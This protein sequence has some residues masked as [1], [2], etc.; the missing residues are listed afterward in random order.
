MPFIH[1]QL[2]LAV[3]MALGAVSIPYAQARGDMGPDASPNGHP[4]LSERVF[5]NVADDKVEQPVSYP[6]PAHFYLKSQATTRNGERL[7]QTIDAAVG[8]LREAGKLTPT[9]EHELGDISR[10]LAGL[11]PGRVGAVLE[12]LAGS[13]NANLASATQISVQQISNTLLSAIHDLPSDSP[14]DADGRLWVKGLSN[15]G[16]LD[17][18]H[19]SAGLQQSTQGVLIGADWDVDHAWRVGVMG[20]KSDNDFSAQRFVAALDSWHLGG[21]AVRQDGPLALRLGAIYSSHT[22]ENKRNVDIDFYSYREQL[23]GKYN[24]QSQT[25]FAEMGYQ[26]GKDAFSAEPFASLGYQRYHRD[27]FKEKGGMA[28]LNVGA[29]TQDNLSSTFGLRLSSLYRLDN[30]MSL[31]P[32]LS[33]SWKHLYGD[34]SS[35]VKQSSRLID[36]TGINSE[37]TIDGTALDRNTLALRTGLDLALS[38]NHTLGI[39]YTAEA[40]SNSRNHGLMGQWQ[41]GF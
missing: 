27:S 38:R 4:I 29:Q 23:S 6:A 16:R 39:A 12:Q 11:A 7:A 40:G 25:A 22:G 13:Q 9:D 1:K 28:A 33:A 36:R 26:I 37:F 15:S 19:G 5:S 34:V 21:Y 14:N 32:H 2:I 30:R 20:G 8:Q 17:S 18:Q 31:T 41:M 24:A 3:S 35:N 10:Y